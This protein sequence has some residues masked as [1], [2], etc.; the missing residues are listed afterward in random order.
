[1]GIGQAVWSRVFWGFVRFFENLVSTEALRNP[2]ALVESLKQVG[3]LLILLRMLQ[4][5]PQAARL[6]S[7]SPLWE[8]SSAASHR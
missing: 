1:M 3:A 6:R 7:D 5:S 8:S 4:Q 2:P